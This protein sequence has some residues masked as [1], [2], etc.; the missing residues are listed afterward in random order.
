[1]VGE[2]GMSREKTDYLNERYTKYFTRHVVDWDTQHWHNIISNYAL[3]L[4]V[5]HHCN[6][7]TRQTMRIQ[8]TTMSVFNE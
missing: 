2:P 1:M 6:C 5:A 8:Q 7:K 4:T 3:H